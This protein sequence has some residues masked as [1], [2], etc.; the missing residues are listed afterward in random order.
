MAR[1]SDTKVAVAYLRASTDKQETS[2]EAQRAS[3]QAWAT[4]QGVEIIAWHEEPKVKGK[5]SGAA[6]IEKRP[7]LLSAVAEVLSRRAA[8][9]VVAR[10]DRFS[11]DYRLTGPLEAQLERQGAQLVSADGTPATK[12]PMA[13]ALRGMADVFARLERGLIAARTSEALQ[14]RRRAGKRAGTV[15]YGFT[16][17]PDG[18]TLLQAP[19]EL[20]TVARARQLRA[21]GLTLRETSERLASEGRCNRKGRPFDLGALHRMTA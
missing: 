14:A 3:I 18:E 20:A 17:A 16:V 5:A 9:L 6:P 19:C 7:A 2:P 10:R 15:P 8:F 12:D 21:E 13:E 4:R 1:K 11:R